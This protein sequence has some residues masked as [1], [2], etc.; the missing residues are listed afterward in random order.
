MLSN[1]LLDDS[2][3]SSRA[4]PV[5]LETTKFIGGTVDCGSLC[6]KL[7]IWRSAPSAGS[8]G[9][10][11]PWK[12]L[13][14]VCLIA[15]FAVYFYYVAPRDSF[16]RRTMSCMM[17]DAR[18]AEEV[19]KI[20]VLDHNLLLLV[21]A[22]TLLKLL[23]EVWGQDTPTWVC[24]GGIVLFVLIYGLG[25][26]SIVVYMNGYCIAK[27]DLATSVDPTLR[28]CFGLLLFLFGS[29]YALSY[30]VGRF[31]WKQ[32]PENK[33]KLHTVG[34]AKYCIHPNYFADIFTYT[35]WAVLAGTT[36]ALSAPLG[37]V[38][39]LVYLVIP[40]SDAYLARK[41]SKEWAG[42][43]AKTATLIPFVHSWTVL[44]ILAWIGFAGS[45]YLGA[46]C[47]GQCDASS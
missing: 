21:G 15:E 36:C 5:D 41:Y 20:P 46:N 19:K 6:R 18:A 37:A 17:T 7:T 14:S 28:A 39:S 31:Q 34:L 29:V 27:R 33:G 35:G 47:A 43:A 24:P 40:N 2:N 13:C 8:S 26:P 30:E 11:R 38:W 9:K 42:Y 1:T 45:V 16:L 10:R 12:F 32:R 22:V 25:L 3:C 4:D 23:I 44:Q